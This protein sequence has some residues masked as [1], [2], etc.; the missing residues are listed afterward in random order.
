[1][2]AQLQAAGSPR[3][4]SPFLCTTKA[5]RTVSWLLASLLCLALLASVLAIVW[6]TNL[7]QQSNPSLGGTGLG[8]IEQFFGAPVPQQALDVLTPEDLTDDPSHIPVASV[9]AELTA[10]VEQLG[11]LDAELV[12]EPPG[13]RKGTGIGDGAE[14]GV[15]VVPPDDNRPQRWSFSI[16]RIAS[17]DE[18]T[19][20]LDQLGIELGTFDVAGFVY[21][22]DVRSKMPGQ[23]R[24][25]VSRDDRFYTV[26]QS[27][28]L[29]QMDHQLFRR[30]GV[31]RLP[32]RPMVHFFSPQLES[33]LAAMELEATRKNGRKLKDIRRTSFNLR[34][35]SGRFV[36]YVGQQHFRN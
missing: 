2:N 31:D 35:Q 28:S 15:I 21:L 11:E 12:D 1:M 14:P 22:T 7:S 36:F 16:D 32:T 25:T 17:I 13:G 3:P 26:W 30:A 5:D 9:E 24:P 33:Q 20:M 10:I 6:L 23:R 8:T 34:K 29:A 18:Y 19:Q 27:G 4:D